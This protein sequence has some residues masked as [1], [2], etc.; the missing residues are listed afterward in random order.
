MNNLL[1]DKPW[2]RE[3]WPWL[4]ASGPLL[5]VV[6]SFVSAW[7]AIKSSDGLVSEDYYRQGL[8]AQETISRSDKA[9]AMG[10]AARVH[11]TSDT[12]SVGLSAKTAD[13]QMP[14]AVRITISHPTRAGL[15]QT[16]LIP[17]EGQGRYVSK[18]RLPAAGHWLILIEDEANNWRMMGSVVLPAGG[19]FQIGA[20]ASHDDHP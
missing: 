15:D 6:A 4:L 14:A 19:E 7:I 8:A 10:L 2:F 1:T 9:I 3:P 17:G 18:Y 20:P 12:L 13:F 16:L 5:V 11:I